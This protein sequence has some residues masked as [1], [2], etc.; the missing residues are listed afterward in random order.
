MKTYTKTEENIILSFVIIS[1][2]LILLGGVSI[3]KMIELSNLTQ[4]LYEHPLVVTNATQKI[5]THLVSMHRYMKDVVLSTSEEELQV[6]L[7]LVNENERMI[8]KDFKL[9]FER[10]LGDK[11]EIQTSYDLFVRWKMIRDEIVIL[12]QEG[13]V[14]EAIQITKEKGYRHVLKLNESVEVL[15]EYAHKKGQLFVQ[16]AS[17][18]KN[19]SISLTVGVLMII[20]IL[21][22]SIAIMLLKSLANATQKREQ[23]TQQL[24]SQSR[25]AQMGEMI[26]MIAHQWRQPLGAIAATSID[27]KMKIELGEFDFEEKESRA[28]FLIYLNHRLENIDSF[29]QGLTGTIDDFRDFYKPNNKKE[30][31]KINIPIQKTLNIV[32]NSL[33]SNNI[34]LVEHYYSERSI[35]FNNSE[36]MQ[37]FL[38]I[39]K[40]SEDNFKAKDV[41]KAYISIT[42]VDTDSGLNIM[43]CDNGGGVDS[44]IKDKI[45]DP[46]FSTK[47]AKNGTG[48]GLYMSKLIIEEHHGGSISV[49]STQDG[50]CFDIALC[51]EFV[52][53]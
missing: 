4:K 42:T 37:V 12:M 9:V 7:H 18:T 33:K 30:F 47:H 29:V 39:F 3:V 53:E 48:L 41:K 34:K 14:K 8:Y 23:Q 31:L 44:S 1:L 46:Y 6:A 13:K 16:N 27:V 21:I 28:D 45:F 20:L 51:K 19:L 24:L 43:I 50:V 52:D 40:N 2:L 22:L 25:L 35:E 32:E 49:R 17:D 5:Q 38:N 36:I 11:Q 26:S 10:Y 15:V